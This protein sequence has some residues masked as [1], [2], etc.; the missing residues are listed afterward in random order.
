MAASEEE[1]EAIDVGPLERDQIRTLAGDAI[2]Q[3]RTYAEALDVD[4][5]TVTYLLDTL[6]EE[7]NV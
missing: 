3:L 2:M 4:M 1:S 6:K 5:E 7:I